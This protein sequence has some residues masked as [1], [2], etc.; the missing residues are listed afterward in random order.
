MI[1]AVLLASLAIICGR[2]A[3]AFTGNG[4]WELF[5]VAGTG[6]LAVMATGF[7]MPP[8]ET[9]AGAAITQ[10]YW[11]RAVDPLYHADRDCPRLNLLELPSREA[12]ALG[13]R[14]PCA[15]CCENSPSTHPATMATV[16]RPIPASK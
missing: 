16:T 8:V 2:A 11:G 13:G 12:A 1:L 5:C 6:C 7:T 9:M 14:S 3:S 4:R 15:Y 10:P